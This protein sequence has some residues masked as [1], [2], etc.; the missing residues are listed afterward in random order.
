MAQSKLAA[1]PR[2]KLPVHIGVIMDGN[3]RW[4][5]KHGL[6]RSAGHRRGAEVFGKIAQHCLKIGIPYLTVYAFSTENWKRPAQ[7][8]ETIMGLL[9]RYLKDTLDSPRD[10]VRLCFLGDRSPLA[11]DLCELMDKIEKGTAANAGIRVNIAL[12]YGG[13]DEIVRAVR[14]IA[15]GCESGRLSAEKIDEQLICANLYTSGQP[16]PDLIIRPSGEYRLSNFLLWQ[17]AYSELVFMDVLWPEFTPS[18]LDEAILT[19]VGRSRR[20]GGTEPTHGLA[21]K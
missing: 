7:E 16:D 2:E 12:N 14:R 3:G 13:R 19:Y 15:G 9:R 8:V 10:D 17:S 1:I 6:P 21:V 18:H 4:A 11:P 20:F 5:K